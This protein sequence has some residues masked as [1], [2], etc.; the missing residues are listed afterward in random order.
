MALVDVVRGIL[1]TSTQQSNIQYFRDNNKYL[2]QAIISVKTLKEK[3]ATTGQPKGL[4]KWSRFNLP[5]FTMDT[6]DFTAE[7]EQNQGTEEILQLGQPGTNLSDF[8]ISAVTNILSQ[9]YNIDHYQILSC[10]FTGYGKRL[11]NNERTILRKLSIRRRVS[12]IN[13]AREESSW[14]YNSSNA[15]GNCNSDV[16]AKYKIDRYT[17]GAD[18]KHK[19]VL[20]IL[21]HEREL[22]LISVG[23]DNK[24]LTL[25][26]SIQR[27]ESNREVQ[28]KD[29]PQ[30]T[31]IR[32]RRHGR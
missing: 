20:Q 16:A 22:I 8:Q 17:L 9:I 25:Y 1:A 10:Q 30:P 27:S 31:Q 11:S 4:D 5:L 18:S 24:C 3:P 29:P 15:M 2:M 19:T 28:A 6:C 32:F 12:N 26:D 14:F 21:R 23:F 13:Y 7:Q